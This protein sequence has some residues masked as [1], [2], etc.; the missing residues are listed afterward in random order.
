MITP[1]LTKRLDD[2][3]AQS[4]VVLFMKWEPESPACGFSA[5]A[6]EIL[7]ENDIQ[8]SSFD[9]YSDEEV[10]QGLKV[11]KSWPTY[12]QLYVDGKLMWGVDIMEEMNDAGELKSI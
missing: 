4:R 9:I 12:P 8:F 6:V 3:I 1:E 5:R 11:Y 2:I 10:R 7:L